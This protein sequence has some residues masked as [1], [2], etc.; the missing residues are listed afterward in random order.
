MQALRSEIKS[1]G[2]F[3]SMGITPSYFQYHS[4]V[5]YLV[6]RFNEMLKEHRI[7]LF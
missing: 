7:N 4:K 3:L 2:M 5:L 6:I 1:V